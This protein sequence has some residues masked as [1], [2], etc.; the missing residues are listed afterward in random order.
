MLYEY[1]IAE[2][3]DQCAAGSDTALFL[4][5]LLSAVSAD[6][7]LCVYLESFPLHGTL[8]YYARHRGGCNYTR[9]R[10]MGSVAG[11]SDYKLGGGWG[12]DE[13][14]RTAKRYDD[15]GHGC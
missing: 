3:R 1:S 14:Q 8:Q 7:V 9:L 10:F 11:E 4:I 13:A 5:V 2:F 15:D 12:R 6:V